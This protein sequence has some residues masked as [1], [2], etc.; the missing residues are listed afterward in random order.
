MSTATLGEH[1]SK[2]PQT[3]G[4]FGFSVVLDI[5]M[6]YQDFELVVKK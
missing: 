5:Q 3:L 4:I 6:L 1:F 2:Y